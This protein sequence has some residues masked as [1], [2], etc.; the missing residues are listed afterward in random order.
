MNLGTGLSIGDIPSNRLGPIPWAE[1]SVDEKLERLRNEINAWRSECARLREQLAVLQDHRHDNASGA[2]LVDLH[3]A[4]HALDQH[5][6]AQ[7][8]NL[9]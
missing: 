7:A 4:E 9:L 6:C 8:F 3:R 5:R 2:V 1:C